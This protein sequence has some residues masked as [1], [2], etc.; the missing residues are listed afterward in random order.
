MS[1]NPDQIVSHFPKMGIGCMSL[2]DSY[3]DAETIL[4][5]AIDAGIS[6]FDTADLYQKGQNESNIGRAIQSKRSEIIL[7][8]KVGNEWNADGMSWSWNPRKN[9]ILRAVE[10]SLK[11]LR[12]EYL[13]LYQLHGGTIDDPWD[14]TLEAFELLK[15]QGKILEFGISSIRPNVIRKVMGM[16]P[17]ATIMMQYNPLDR[18][19]EEEVFPFLEKTNTR[20]LVRGAFA[21]GILID[22]AL[23]GFLDFPKER[24]A[25]IKSEIKTLGFSP[26]AVLIRYGLV[27]KAV[28]S[29]IIGASSVDQIK[30][31]SKGYEE[32]KAIP[33]ALIQ[34]LKNKFTPN[35]YQDHR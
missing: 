17:P 18:R 22:K 21:K 29:L 14:E 34:G 23:A 26:E 16:D 1:D 15:R 19:P 35:L 13:D 6:F 24:V 11:R 7:A 4:H 5:S 28:S 10:G 31:I 12:T 3:F 20:V 9:Y 33:E 8:S 2:P 27:E 25:E 32:S 30:K